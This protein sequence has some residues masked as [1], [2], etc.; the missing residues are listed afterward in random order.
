[1]FGQSSGAIGA[2]S[3]RPNDRRTC[4]PV[5]AYQLTFENYWCNGGPLELGWMLSYF[6]DMAE[7]VCTGPVTTRPLPNWQN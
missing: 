4:I 6:V 2:I 3:R 7:A 1:M 5:S